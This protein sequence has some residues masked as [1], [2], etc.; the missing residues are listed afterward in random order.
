MTQCEPTLSR[1][2]LLGGASALA[3]VTLASPSFLEWSACAA[4]AAEEGGDL[5]LWAMKNLTGKTKNFAMQAAGTALNNTMAKIG[6]P[7]PDMALEEVLGLIGIPSS[8]PNAEVNRKLD[9]IK[10]QLDAMNRTVEAI[11]GRISNLQQQLGIAVLRIDAHV[12]EESYKPHV[13]ALEHLFGLPQS[14]SGQPSLMSL[15]ATASRGQR[16]DGDAFRATIESTVQN[17]IVRIADAL[18][19]TVGQDVGLLEQWT[20][21]LVAQ[22]PPE[23]TSEDNERRDKLRT[24]YRLLESYFKQAL[25]AQLKGVTLRVAALG[26]TDPASALRR[27]RED[28]RDILHVELEM[29]LWCVERMVFSVAPYVAGSWQD[30]L[31]LL[32][33]ADMLVTGLRAVWDDKEGS[34]QELFGG[35]FGRIL[36]PDEG[37]CDDCVVIPDLEKGTVRIVATGTAVEGVLAEKSVATRTV[38]WAENGDGAYSLVHPAPQRVKIV[39]TRSPAG[40]QVGVVP[41]IASGQALPI[42]PID[43]TTLE[44][45]GGPATVFAAAYVDG[46]R[47][48]TEPKAPPI[49]P[50]NF[51]SPS[52]ADIIERQSERTPTGYVNSFTFVIDNPKLYSFYRVP[53]ELSAQYSART[54]LFMVKSRDKLAVLVSG[55]FMIG[56]PNFMNGPQVNQRVAIFV[57]SSRG[58]K[59]PVFDST[60]SYLDSW[61]RNPNGTPIVPVYGIFPIEAEADTRYDLLIEFLPRYRRGGDGNAEYKERVTL[62]LN[63]VATLRSQGVGFEI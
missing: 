46:T 35:T 40:R 51:D 39:R 30:N 41:R 42:F 52:F 23:G 28:F 55:S 62:T 53:V 7:T 37:D 4:E 57:T 20:T 18:T 27:A 34:L 33:R 13:N 17:H 1:R 54:P 63:T 58:M 49:T 21:L 12:S 43:L 16:A 38:R 9:E 19:T 36:V 48:L 6:I 15:M 11:G 22:I 26:H 2:R 10:Q 44:Q 5:T 8:S 32:R 56:M 61:E 59:I 25:G 31:F 3:A 60:G 24:G 14:Y 29:F 50:L 45:F 47:A